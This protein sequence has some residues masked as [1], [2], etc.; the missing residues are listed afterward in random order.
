[1]NYMLDSDTCI[2]MHNN[3]SVDYFS[4]LSHLEDKVEILLSSIVLSELQYGVYNSDRIEDNQMKL[5][6]FLEGVKIVPYN[7]K[8]AAY[9]GKIRANLR[10]QGTPI[11]PNDLFIAAHAIA[12]NATLITNN[13]REFQRIKNLKVL[14]WQE[15]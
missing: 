1:M 14:S 3:V 11:G 6:C 10:R 8:C 7:T 5:Q 15:L 13:T 2:Y 9:Y 12:E 4:K